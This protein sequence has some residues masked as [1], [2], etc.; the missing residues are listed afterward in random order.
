MVPH[1]ESH[2]R[3]GEGEVTGM[4]IPPFMDHDSSASNL[5]G[6]FQENM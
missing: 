5:N 1:T 3:D 4:L 2:Q 6:S